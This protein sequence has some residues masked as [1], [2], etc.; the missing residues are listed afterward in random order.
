MNY[1]CFCTTVQ[2][3]FSNNDLI[4]TNNVFNI[5]DRHNIIR[6]PSSLKNITMKK[7]KVKKL[8]MDWNKKLI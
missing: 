7:I 1:L 3:V 2:N 6:K 4:I 8:Y 5:E